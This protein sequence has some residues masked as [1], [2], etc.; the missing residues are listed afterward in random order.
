MKKTTLFTL[1][2]AAC[3]VS[4]AA[5]QSGIDK[6]KPVNVVFILAD[7]LGYG[8]LGCYGQEI[9]RTP[10]LDRM[11][12][13]GLLFSQAYAGCPVSAPSRCSLMTGLNTAHS[14]IRGN[15]EILPEGQAPMA[16]GTFTIARLM[17]QAG[18]STGLFGKWGLGAPNSASV[19][20]SMGFDEFFGYNC[21]RQAHSYYPDHLWHNRDSVYFPENANNAQQTYSQDLIHQHALDFIRANKDKPFFAMLTY[22]LPHA[23]LNLPHDS[24]YA[25]YDGLF[26]EIPYI[27]KF[28]HEQGGYNTSRKPYASFAAMVSRLDWYVG[29]VLNELR[30]LGIDKNTLVIFTSDNGPHAEGGANPSFFKSSGPLRG[31]KRDVYEGGIR[32][33]FIAWMPGTIKDGGRT[34]QICAFWDI[35]P[36]LAEL[37]DQELTEPTDGISILPTILGKDSEEQPQPA[38]LYWA[39][40]EGVKRQALRIGDWKLIRQVADG[41]ETT[42]L[43]DLSQDIGE[44]RDLAREKP[45]QVS[46]LTIKLDSIAGS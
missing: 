28:D 21:Q 31:M 25:Q 11:A 27:G 18:Y 29:S 43:Y 15:Q 8:D 40:N 45:N 33:P 12:N 19:P 2:T 44:T 23:E 6:D 13:E 22:T 24:I 38:Y 17:K 3:A 30:A 36:T 14:Q 5:C 46:L 1:S 37:T 10:N 41:V 20:N 9:I 26:G 4:L 7:D 34:E 39:F 42:E 35:M 32:V 16:E